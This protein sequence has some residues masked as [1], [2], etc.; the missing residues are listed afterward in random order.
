MGDI[1]NKLAYTV[2]EVAYSDVTV[3]SNF[4]REN[5]PYIAMAASMGLISTKITRDVYGNAWKPTTGG[6]SLLAEKDLLDD[7]DQGN[8]PF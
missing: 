1:H 8:L 7:D 3:S 2:R 5:A 4:A 6:L